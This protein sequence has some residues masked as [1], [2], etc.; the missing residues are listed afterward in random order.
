[1]VNKQSKCCRPT[2]HITAKKPGIK[3]VQGSPIANFAKLTISTSS[4]LKQ[5]C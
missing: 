2:P 4:P 5:Y 1:M 3:L